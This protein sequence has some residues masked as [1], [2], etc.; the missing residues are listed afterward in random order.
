MQ[1]QTLSIQTSI[2]SDIL[3][4][5]L[6]KGMIFA[7]LKTLLLFIKLFMKSI[8]QHTMLYRARQVIKLT[9][10]LLHFVCDFDKLEPHRQFR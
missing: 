2:R 6:K 10:V 3:D 5:I 4:I 9:Q 1:R 7:T 8:M